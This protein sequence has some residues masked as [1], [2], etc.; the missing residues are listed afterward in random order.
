M[1]IQ[2]Y[3]ANINGK[4]FEE[5]IKKQIKQYGFDVSENSKHLLY[6]KPDNKSGKGR[7]D[8]IILHNNTPYIRIECK[9]INVNGST[10]EK[11]YYP[12]CSSIMGHF[13][14]KYFVLIIN[15]NIDKFYPGHI[16]ALKDFVKITNDTTIILKESEL[17]NFLTKI[18]KKL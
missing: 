10:F 11:N 1:S 13:K 2:G 9:F 17:S 14:E 8:I 18:K 12:I 5:N 4:L 15:D 16:N 6:E 7:S 3:T